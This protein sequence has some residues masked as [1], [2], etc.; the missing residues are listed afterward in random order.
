MANAS[1]A[2]L[3]HASEELKNLVHDE[4][5]ILNVLKAAI[6]ANP[7]IP[8]RS[9]VLAQEFLAE[10]MNTLWDHAEDILAISIEEVPVGV[11]EDGDGIKEMVS[12]LFL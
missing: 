10:S 5:A 2:G 1:E 8:D 6:E 9:K 7:G 4:F 3:I 11:V 12:T